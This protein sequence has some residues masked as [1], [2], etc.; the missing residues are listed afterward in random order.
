M[1]MISTKVFPR[2]L[3]FILVIVAMSTAHA[4]PRYAQI[5]AIKDFG[6]LPQQAF[7]K[8]RATEDFHF[9]TTLDRSSPVKWILLD[10]HRMPQTAEVVEMS[11]GI[12]HYIEAYYIDADGNLIS[13][14][15]IRVGRSI[16]SSE[17]T[18]EGMHAAFTLPR[19]IAKYR[20][21]LAK[22]QMSN[23]LAI[24]ANIFSLSDFRA[25]I[26]ERNRVF[27]LMAGA[28]LMLALQSLVLWSASGER[29]YWWLAACLM[30]LIVLELATQGYWHHYFAGEYPWISMRTVSLCSL[31]FVYW[32]KKL[33]LSAI[34]R[35]FGDVDGL[36]HI[37]KISSSGCVIIAFFIF[38]GD[39]YYA[40]AILSA[41]AFIVNW[42][43]I[44][45]TL[46][47]F[48]GLR[49]D[50]FVFIFAHL[51]ILSLWI[52][53]LADIFGVGIFV[54]KGF[55][56]VE[57]YQYMY[58]W[59]GAGA[60]VYFIITKRT[61]EVIRGHLRWQQN[62]IG[63]MESA[64]KER[65]RKLTD[66]RHEAL[67]I[68]AIQR[69]YL[70]TLSHELRTPLSAIISL[71]KLISDRK[72]NTPTTR[73]DI[74]S[75]NR[76]SRHTLKLVDR[77][78]AYLRE[79]EIE[80]EVKLV[81]VDM[82]TFQKDIETI[83]SWLAE[84]LNNKFS[85]EHSS[86]LPPIYFDESK[87]RQIVINLLSNAGRYCKNGVIGLKI[88]YCTDQKKL[89]IE[90]SDTGKGMTADEIARYM[91]PFERSESSE[92][93]GLGLH[94]CC[95]L[96]RLLNAKLKI[97]SRKGVG[98]TIFFEMVAEESTT[99]EQTDF[100]SV[101]DFLETSPAK[102]SVSLDGM[103]L[104]SH[105][106]KIKSLLFSLMSCVIDGRLSDAE[107]ELDKIEADN[108]SSRSPQFVC[109]L[110]EH[111]EMLDFNAAA[112]LIRAEIDYESP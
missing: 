12:I 5:R 20:Y 62:L 36:K 108:Y 52:T 2:A 18:V 105:S 50:N 48:R 91:L 92:G 19:D 106:P 43:L 102:I 75:I 65:T 74:D 41:F 28:V 88:S 7:D 4:L 40:V 49:R 46:Y 54:E 57:E 85:I 86:N 70:G 94:I 39:F 76:L 107:V 23:R 63:K 42:T 67:R 60:L 30:T 6:F 104:E 68:S 22:I 71:C 64:V 17:W 66:S 90:V 27:F 84:Q 15:P 51:C 80:E 13:E 112:N 34:R 45:A 1:K 32:Y 111:L 14:V 26:L 103:P 33:S 58:M 87:V 44:G 82:M 77:A 95:T 35:Q 25:E 110:R 31:M 99:S 47:V 81:E 61:S 21:L 53:R 72:K 56:I 78:I 9:S 11:P 83:G 55:P 98:T 73:A 24:R 3:W 38:F 96:C 59:M 16:R 10:R 93:L 37:E 97:Q 109:K 8:L 89:R 100:E 69:D 79:G 29:A 101:R